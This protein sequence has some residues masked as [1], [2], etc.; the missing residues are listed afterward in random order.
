[1]SAQRIPLKTAQKIQQYLRS[2]LSLPVSENH[3]RSWTSDADD[4]PAPDSLG[5]LGD[6]FSFGSP[7]QAAT[8]AP[9][10]RGQW[11]ISSINPGAALLK[12]PGLR[13]KP[14]LRLVSYLHRTPDQGTGVTW[15]VPEPLS[16]TM[17]LEQAL[18]DRG[19]RSQPPRPAGALEN[20]MEAMEGDRSLLSFLVASLL[21]RELQELGALGKSCRWSHHRLIDTL[22][23]PVAC[24][25]RSQPPQNLLPKGRIL[26]DGRAAIEFFS[27]RTVAPIAIF[28]HLDQ[29]SA[30]DY[31]A[32]GSDRAIGLIQN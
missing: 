28:Q 2:H 22:P 4:R 18:I 9:N 13:L 3:P 32:V 6:L 31:T 7:V 20:V 1:M 5:A 12:L 14:G 19:D 29:Y 26:P 10:T 27:C 15:A 17:H 16:T 8:F 25:W 23:D 30:K 11:F 24:Q 21:R